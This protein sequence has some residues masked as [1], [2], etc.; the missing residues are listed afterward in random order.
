MCHSF[1]IPVMGTGFTVDTP[2]RVAHLGISSAISIVDDLLLEKIR[3]FYTEKFQLPYERIRAG[4]V[5]GRARRITAYL[6]M[7]GQI[8]RLKME[9]LKQQPFFADN[10]KRTYFELLPDTAPLRRAYERMVT[11]TPGPRRDKLAETLTARMTPGDIDVNIMVKVDRMPLDKSGAP[12]GEAFSDAK[13]ALRGYANSCLESSSLIF[14]AG[15]NKGLFRYMTRF[16]DFYRDSVGSIRK[17]I[18]LKVSDFR[19]AMIQG[20]FLAQLGLEVGEYRI[21]SGLNCGGHAFAA[22]IRLLPSIVSEFKAKREQ[23]SSG[24]HALVSTYYEK[25]GWPLAPPQK[26][27]RPLVTVQGGIGTHGETRRLQEV[28][29][30]D[31]T[32]WGTPFL[33]VPQAVCVDTDLLSLMCRAGQKDLYLSGISPLGVP[34]NH[35]R[36]TTSEHWTRERAAQGRPGSGC[37]KQFLASNTEFTATPVCQASGRFQRV[38]LAQIMAGPGSDVDKQK[39]AEA[40]LEKTCICDHLGNSALMALGIHRPGSLPT[41]VCPGPNLAWFDRPYSLREMVDHIYGRGTNLAAADRPHMFAQELVM[42]VDFFARQVVAFDGSTR[43]Q[44]RLETLKATLSEEMDVC[45]DISRS[46]AFPGENLVSIS[47]CVTEQRQR[48]ED[49]WQKHVAGATRIRQLH[50]VLAPTSACDPKD[51]GEPFVAKPAVFA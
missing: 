37:P 18:T 1:H 22:N 3:R 5:D 26:R 51:T 46:R 4:E 30:A 36:N 2:I 39:R 31:R 10:E 24:F 20:K 23:L 35:L 8:V 7:V 48:V 12:L 41:V 38:K 11:M 43:E 40:V 50:P 9:Q 13:A 6:D 28:L 15:L 25:M 34:M 32:G 27:N 19:S 42:Y 45:M 17:K 14:S 29:G 49:I 47:H 21:E 44:K 16:R 33:L